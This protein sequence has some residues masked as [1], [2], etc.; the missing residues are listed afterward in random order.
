MHKK[1]S[2]TLLAELVIFLSLGYSIY[3]SH[4]WALAVSVTF[5]AILLLGVQEMCQDIINRLSILY[6]E[7]KKAQ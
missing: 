5:I 1:K 4:G 2:L 7:V 6:D 3:N